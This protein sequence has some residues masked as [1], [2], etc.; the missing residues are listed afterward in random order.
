MT[1]D[2]VETAYVELWGMLVGAVAWDR[3]RGFATFEFDRAFLER[4]Q[5]IAVTL[6][7]GGLFL[8]PLCGCRGTFR[9]GAPSC[10]TLGGVLGRALTLGCVALGRKRL[11]LGGRQPVIGTPPPPVKPPAPACVSRAG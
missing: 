5:P 6:Y 1:A 2:R 7:A 8:I 9:L 11:T 10:C 3:E 4:G